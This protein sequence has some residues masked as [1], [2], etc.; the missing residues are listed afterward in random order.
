MPPD[1]NQIKNN[2]QLISEKLCTLHSYIAQSSMNQNILE[3]IY[4]KL[5]D[6]NENVSIILGNL[7]KKKTE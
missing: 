6:L 5:D 1:L 3:Y 2:F 7:P 4:Q